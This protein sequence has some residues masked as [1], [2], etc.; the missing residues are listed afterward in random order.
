M[1]VVKFGGS[2]VADAKQI[3]K[4]A[5]IVKADENRRIVVVSAPGKRF[6]DDTKV[7]DL[8]IACAHAVLAGRD[9]ETELKAVVSRYAEIQQEL[10]LAPQIV[11]TIEADLR[12]RIAN[13]G[14]NDAQR[15][16]HRNALESHS[17]RRWLLL[18]DNYVHGEIGKG[19]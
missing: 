12:S 7:T 14:S 4:V 11:F 17:D 18:P 8:L 19:T 5:G 3:L 2:S 10:K 16:G 1:K 15:R 13:R 9:Y 6:S